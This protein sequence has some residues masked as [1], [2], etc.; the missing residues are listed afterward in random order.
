MTAFLALL[1]A[2][3]TLVYLACAT[4]VGALLLVVLIVWSTQNRRHLS[5]AEMVRMYPE[6]RRP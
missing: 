2:V 3:W 1:G 6:R 5:A 4:G